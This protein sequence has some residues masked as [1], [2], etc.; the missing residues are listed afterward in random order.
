MPKITLTASVSVAANSTNDNVLQNT[1]V[2]NVPVD[3]NYRVTFLATGSA[4][5]LLH[6]FEADTDI[7][8][9]ESIAGAQNRVPLHPDDFVDEWD[10][11]GGSKLFLKVE[12]T[13]AGALTHFHTVV[14]TPHSML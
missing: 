11:R 7:A 13:T 8:V 3:D 6:T 5:G 14:L 4:T 12:N 9:Q 1:K 2:E 10:V